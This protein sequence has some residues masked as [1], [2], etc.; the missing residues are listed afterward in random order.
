MSGMATVTGNI[1]VV[2]KMFWKDFWH[3]CQL[4]E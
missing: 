3:L 1:L 2:A 4:L